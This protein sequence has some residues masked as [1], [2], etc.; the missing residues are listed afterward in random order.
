MQETKDGE[1]IGALALSIGARE[2]A[3]LVD[4]SGK[5]IARV[6]V[7]GKYHKEKVRLVFKAPQSVTILREP[8]ET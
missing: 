8:N 2:H 4:A 7:N 6:T 5:V 3:V 1:K